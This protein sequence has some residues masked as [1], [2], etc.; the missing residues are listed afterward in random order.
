MDQN[1]KLLALLTS[2]GHGKDT[3]SPATDSNNQTRGGGVRREKRL[4]K[5]CKKEGYHEDEECFTL[6]KNATK[7]PSWYKNKN[8]E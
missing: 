3:S 2:G 1:T 6:A 4:C 7:R 8:G 5:N